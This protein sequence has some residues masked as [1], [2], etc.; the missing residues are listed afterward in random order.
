MMDYSTGIM[1]MIPVRKAPYTIEAPGYEK[2]PGE[3]V[4]RRHPQAK[5]GLLTRPDNDVHTVLDIVLRS[6]RV[7]PNHQAVGARKLVKLHKEIKIISSMDDPAVDIEKEWR[8]YELTPYEYLTYGE[9]ETL[10]LQIGS[11]LRQVGLF[12]E[13]KVHIFATTR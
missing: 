1:P 9:Y 8:F 4:P 5:N 10:V 3:T 6:A 11:G 12:A 7:Y 2:I 13:D